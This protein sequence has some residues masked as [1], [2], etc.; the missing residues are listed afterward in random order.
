MFA[1]GQA[2][3]QRACGRQAL[4]ESLKALVA[5]ADAVDYAYAVVG[6]E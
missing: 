2:V 4:P 5:V 6:Y 1:A 3:A